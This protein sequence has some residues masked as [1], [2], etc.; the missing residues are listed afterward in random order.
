MHRNPNTVPLSKAQMTFL[1]ANAPAQINWMTLTNEAIGAPAT[2]C[3]PR[4]RA[5]L[6]R[7]DVITPD[8][9][10]TATGINAWKRK[11]EKLKR[12]QAA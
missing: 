5:A 3:Q 12:K 9:Q 4:T 6:V 2:A 10:I 11:I 8:G 1:D 7:K